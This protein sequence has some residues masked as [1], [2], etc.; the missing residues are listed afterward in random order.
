[1]NMMRTPGDA[2]AS[3]PTQV[4]GKAAYPRADDGDQAIASSASGVQ[5]Q[6]GGSLSCP[7]RSGR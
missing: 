4:H 1:M 3:K 2:Q 6:P 5:A 7:C